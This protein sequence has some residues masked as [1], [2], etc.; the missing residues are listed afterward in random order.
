MKT[1]GSSTLVTVYDGN[2]YFDISPEDCFL[3]SI[4]Y[5]EVLLMTHLSALISLLMT[6]DISS[7]LLSTQFCTGHYANC[8][9][10]GVPT[11]R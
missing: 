10:D 3:S 6:N 4:A 5:E 8:T 1:V 9:F 7:P 2:D 11:R